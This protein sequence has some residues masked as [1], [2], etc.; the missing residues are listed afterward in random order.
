MIEGY[1]KPVVGIL[2]S[3]KSLLGG[4]L[5]ALE[6]KFGRADIT[7]EWRSFDHTNYYEGEMGGNLVRCFVSFEKLVHP[8]S[9]RKFKE[10]ARGI[11]DRYR[12]CGARRVNLDPGYIDANKVVLI[13]G[14]HGGHRI[15]LAKGV[16]ADPLLWYNKVW[17]PLPWTYPDF[18][19]GGFFPLFTR[20]R[21]RF[22]RQTRG[23]A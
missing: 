6:E 17:Q 4:V 12:R 22:K 2:L 23:L 15:A 5:D 19:D 16:W 14:K 9:A 20:M 13:T 18:R 21:D 10:W 1:V 11:E 7:G 8:Q 3:D